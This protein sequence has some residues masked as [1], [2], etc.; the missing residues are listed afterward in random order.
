MDI[1]SLDTNL[2]PYVALK[3]PCFLSL[4]F[5]WIEVFG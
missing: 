1:K 2:I 3:Q 5:F 4:F